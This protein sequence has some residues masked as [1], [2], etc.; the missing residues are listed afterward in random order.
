MEEMG[1]RICVQRRAV[2]DII[3]SDRDEGREAI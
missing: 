1:G 3:L 2:Y